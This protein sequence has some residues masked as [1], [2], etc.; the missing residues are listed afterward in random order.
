MQAKESGTELVY[1]RR[2]MYSSLVDLSYIDAGTNT[3]PPSPIAARDL[4]TQ[5]RASN[6]IL[7]NHYSRIIIPLC[8]LA[9]GLLNLQA[10]RAVGERGSVR[11]LAPRSHHNWGARLGRRR[12]DFKHKEPA[13]LTQL[14]ELAQKSAKLMVKHGG[15]A[16]ESYIIAMDLLRQQYNMN[17]IVMCEKCNGSHLYDEIIAPER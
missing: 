15:K 6:C 12:V 1:Q 8:F 5:L 7:E 11:P 4:S 13:T 17:F 14:E 2:R 9:H 3:P 10:A 16:E